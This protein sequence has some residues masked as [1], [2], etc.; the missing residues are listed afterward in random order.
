MQPTPSESLPLQP[1][2]A[3][4]GFSLVEV[5]ATLV[6]TMILIVGLTP[7]VRQM[8]ATWSRG[9]EVARA[10]E[11]E[12][13]GIGLLRGDLR[14]AITWT[15]FGNIDN[16]ATFRGT[17]TSISF[18]AATGLDAGRNGVEMLSFTVDASADGR[19][20]V[21]RRATLLGTTYLGFTD[22][23]VLFSGPL[24]YLFHYI[25]R[26][27]QQLQVWNR[28]ELPASIELLIIDQK[29]PI[30]SAPIALPV[31]ASLSAGCLVSQGLPGCPVTPPKDENEWMKS[32]GLK[33][34]DE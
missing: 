9:S 14:H 13:R 6:V 2:T 4:A 20:L 21:R 30:F 27:G 25:G 26:D 1:T 10:V 28:P 16:L 12:S 15:G 18:P 3:E 22:P 31:F 5:L 32:Y 34:E 11:L 7:F 8:L 17:E 29:G 24:K 23:I 33:D 19:A